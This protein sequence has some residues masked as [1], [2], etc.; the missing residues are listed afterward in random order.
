MATRSADLSIPDRVALAGAHHSAEPAHTATLQFIDL[1]FITSE[2]GPVVEVVR[3]RSPKASFAYV[4][5]PNVDHLVRLQRNRSD[6][7]PAYRNAWMTLCDSRILAGLAGRS[8][9]M[10]PVIPGSDLTALMFEQVIAPD[11]RIAIVGGEASAIDALARRY[12]LRDV[13]HHNPPMGFINNDVEVAK[14]I[15]FL[16]DARARYCFLALGSP[17]QEILAYRVLRSGGATGI[18]FCVGASLD[19]LTG[20]Q[21]RAPALLQ[22]MALEWL[23]RLLLNPRRLWRRYLVDGPEIFGIARAWNRARSQS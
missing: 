9:F 1:D 6:L 20:A 16:I 18:G 11:D 5:T 12:R 7:W 14:A 22:R 8:G 19:F 23:Y 4:V 2:A 21:G 13:R 17:Q 15:H 10:L 3:N